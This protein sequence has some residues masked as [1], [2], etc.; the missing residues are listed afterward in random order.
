MYAFHLT[1]GKLN[2]SHIDY[3]S[4][5]LRGTTKNWGLIYR[6]TAYKYRLPAYLV[7]TTF[8][9][10]TVTTGPDAISKNQQADMKRAVKVEK[11]ELLKF[12]DS[13]DFS[14]LEV[15]HVS[16]KYMHD[17]KDSKGQSA[18]VEQQRISFT[19]N[20]RSRDGGRKLGK[21]SDFLLNNGMYLLESTWGVVNTV[22][23]E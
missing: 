2:F 7:D 18:Q 6:F 4:L 13:Y 14:D 22:E 8:K 3:I 19:C 16:D 1:R 11:E 10:K 20:L 5:T 12:I 15:G 23:K 17:T 21:E 9:F